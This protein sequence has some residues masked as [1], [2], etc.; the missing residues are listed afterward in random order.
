M[1]E[2]K[3]YHFTDKGLFYG[4]STLQEAMEALK[5][6]AQFTRKVSYLGLLSKTQTI[7]IQLNSLGTR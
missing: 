1:S 4:V 2:S 6:G 3:F 5:E 7:Q